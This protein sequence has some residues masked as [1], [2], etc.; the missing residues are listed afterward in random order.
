MEP[1]DGLF[2]QLV[3]IKWKKDGFLNSKTNKQRFIHYL[4][5]YQSRKGIA[6]LNRA[7]NDADVLI[8][9]TAVPSV[10]HKYTLQ[11]CNFWLPVCIGKRFGS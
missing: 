6:Y 7:N 10:R 8:V 9:E 4:I 3:V 5:Q 11:P 2:V 1:P